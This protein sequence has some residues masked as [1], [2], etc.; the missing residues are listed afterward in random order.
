MYCVWFSRRQG[1]CWVTSKMD[2]V[3]QPFSYP[4]ICKKHFESKYLTFGKQ[5]RTLKRHLNPIPTIYGDGIS[6]PPSI[7]PTPTTTRKAPTVHTFPVLDDRRGSSISTWGWNSGISWFNCWDMSTRLFVWFFRWKR[8]VFQGRSYKW[9]PRNNRGYQS[10]H[11]YACSTILQGFTG[12]TAC[13]VPE[14]QWLQATEKECFRKFS[15]T[16]SK[17]CQQKN[18]ATI[19]RWMLTMKKSP[20]PLWLWTSLKNFVTRSLLED[21]SIRQTFSAMLFLSDILQSKRTNY[22]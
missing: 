22:F 4:G 14:E 6:I 21:L 9:C 3:C 17:F 8:N 11:W 15:A 12:Y 18:E 2:Q 1:K 16:H 7:L 5:R 19:L 20:L 13:L 10:R